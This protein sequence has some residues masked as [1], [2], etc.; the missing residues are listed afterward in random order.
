MKSSRLRTV[1][2]K[3]KYLSEWEIKE[4]WNKRLDF[5]T[6]KEKFDFNECY[7]KFYKKIVSYKEIIRCY[8]TVTNKLA[9]F[10]IN[11]YEV[12]NDKKSGK[13]W[14]EIYPE[15]AF[16]D[17]EYRGNSAVV[18]YF[19]K[20]IF[21]ALLISR[22]KPVYIVSTFYP[23][24][25]LTLHKYGILTFKDKNITNFEK[26]ILT[27]FAEREY[28]DTWQK[29]SCIVELTTIPKGS[30]ESS[31]IKN[32]INIFKSYEEINP[33]WRKGFG[34]IVL[35]KVS[36]KKLILGFFS[37]MVGRFLNAKKR[38]K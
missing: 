29:G 6:I 13:K 4:L 33:D 34:C 26:N 32:Y 22:L 20:T 18:K 5:I 9:G 23:L 10:Y 31:R 30:M 27:E 14:V 36:V 35:I 21:K 11:H 28:P 7:K 37:E 19:V 17:K 3:G 16:F 25:Y 1:E 8:D 2:T 12:K 15:Y 38:V 24:G